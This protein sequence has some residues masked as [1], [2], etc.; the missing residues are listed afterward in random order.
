[1]KRAITKFALR[2]L[3]VGVAFFAF[4]PLA[5]AH[6]LT[7]QVQLQARVSIAT[8]FGE[9][10]DHFL[11]PPLSSC[12]NTSTDNIKTIYDHNSV[13]IGQ[14]NQ[15][16]DDST[17]F[18]VWAGLKDTNNPGNKCFTITSLAIYETNADYSA[19]G[20]LDSIP[21]KMCSPG[22]WEST[23]MNGYALDGQLYDDHSHSVVTDENGFTGLTTNTIN[24]Q[25]GRV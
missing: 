20:A 5:S 10:C 23:K 16:S 6:T 25:Y 22:Q 4:A 15:F 17:C 2:A 8:C 7:T 12:I 3:F 13:A 19:Q 1:M 24:V 21:H 9:G 18:A 14:L 11:P